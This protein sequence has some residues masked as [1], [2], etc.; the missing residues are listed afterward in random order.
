MCKAVFA[1]VLY[2]CNEVIC[3]FGLN[4]WEIIKLCSSSTGKCKQLSSR[5]IVVSCILM[6]VGSLLFA[7]RALHMHAEQGY[8]IF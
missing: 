5:V 3:M 7:F 6:L 4:G 8:Q 2:E 1:Y